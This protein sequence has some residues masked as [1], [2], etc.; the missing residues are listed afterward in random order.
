MKKRLERGCLNCA[1]PATGWQTIYCSLALII[2]VLFIMLVSYAI[3]DKK[4]MNALKGTFA[5][6]GAKQVHMNDTKT[7]ANV[8]KDEIL[9]DAG[10]VNNAKR[11]LSLLEA[12]SGL[13][14]NVTVERFHGGMR[15][16]FRSDVVFPVGSA[17]ISE[18]IYP[19]LDEMS[20]V[21]KEYNLSLRVEGHTDD[22]P[23]RSVEFPSNWELSTAR[24]ANIIR[25][26]ITKCGFPATRLSAEGYSQY[27][28]V[29]PNG[30][31]EGREKNRRIEV[32]F[33]RNR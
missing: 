21:A 32:F 29:A 30:T 13:K 2:V 20:R 18:S 24:A 15:C 31:P 8:N 16:K 27:R 12:V 1:E 4:K 11:S 26:F 10:W 3:A 23:I 6:S 17:M 28:P 14:S 9:N 19:Y 25:Y 33:E 5:G 7:Y 22:V